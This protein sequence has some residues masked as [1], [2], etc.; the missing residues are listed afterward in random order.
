MGEIEKI[1]R[2]IDIISR[3]SSIPEDGESFDEISEA[4]DVAIDVMSREIPKMVTI[5][6]WSPAYCPKC[7]KEL[8][9]HKGDGWYVHPTF[10]ERCP[11]VDCIQRLEW[12][13]NV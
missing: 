7:G 12:P 1:Q 9:E 8:S 4:Y 11:N 10:L 3:K 6:D 13:D 5:K 2:S